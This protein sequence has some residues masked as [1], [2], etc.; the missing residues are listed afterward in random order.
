MSAR[1][2]QVNPDIRC[3]IWFGA[4]SISPCRGQLVRYI[5]ANRRR[6]HSSGI[7]CINRTRAGCSA[8]PVSSVKVGVAC[9]APHGLGDVL[10]ARKVRIRL[11][12]AGS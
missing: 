12:L 3:S 2:R 7:A 11:P 1:R 6:I 4:S 8:A 10:C 5:L 9:L